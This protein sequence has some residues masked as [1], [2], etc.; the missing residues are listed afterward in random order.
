[1]RIKMV[2]AGNPNSGKT[3]LFNALTGANQYV[4]NWPGV[5]VEK[6][7]GK[8]KSS[9][10]KGYEDIES[11]LVD[12]PGIYSLSPYTLEEVV[13]RN[14]ILDDK[15]DVIINIIDGSNLERNLYLTT[16]LA[17]L[18]IPMVLA[19]NM[20][21]ILKKN[22]DVLD[23]KML[24]MQLGCP[25]VEISALKGTG[26]EELTVKAIETAKLGIPAAVKHIFSGSVEHALAHIEEETIHDMP[27]E[28]QR[29][30]AIKLF[31]KD[32]KIIEKLDI[33]KEALS[34]I[35]RD[36]SICENEMDDDVESIITN[37]RYIFVAAVTGACLKKKG[38]SNLTMSDK[39]DRIVTNRILGLP[40]F[41]A[42]MFV[43][44]FV[45]VTTIGTRATDWTNDV[46]FG[47]WISNAAT[48]GLESIGASDWVQSL[49]V[50]GIIGGIGAPIGFTPQMALVFLFLSFLEDCGY[51]ARVAFIMDRIFRRF[52]LSGKSFIPFLISSGCAVPGIMATRT[53]ENEK[54]RRMTIMTTTAIPCGAKLPVIAAI[55]GFLMG[56]AWWMAPLMYFVGIG[57]AIM[58]CIILKKMKPF[59]GKPAPFVMELPKYH[60]PSIGTL[61]LHTWERVWAF[62]KKAGTILFA[63]CVV[64]WFLSSF[65]FTNGSFGLVEAEDS[66]MAAIGGFIAPIFIPLGFGTWQ[67]VASSIS[68]FVAKEGI[69]S[70]MGVLSG[71]GEIEDYSASMHDAFA[72][73]FPTSIAAVSFLMFNLF[74]SPCLAAISSAA[75]EYGSKRFF[76]FAIAF[77]NIMA[78]CIALLVYQIG[79]LAVG[80][81]SFG[82]GTIVAFIILAAMLYMLFRPDPSKKLERLARDGNAA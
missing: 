5:T 24:E 47:T 51:M 54:D 3:T 76:W 42:V 16:Q 13:A 41:V 71:L 32:E 50:D 73:F 69:I 36:I 53:I 64:M 43:V 35:E 7:S 31:E 79:G 26:I 82:V 75:K 60:I 6:K 62:L 48:K 77:Q 12:L 18:G 21:D 15:P 46:L 80:A 70:T 14:Y 52:G 20:I 40:I 10:K 29:F 33:S 55:A 74:D 72:S 49:V 56:G 19:V 38:K 4:G 59:C 67:S 25:A 78:Y 23:T 57:V 61:L 1:M 11:E 45:S 30:Y 81:I 39:I 27:E 63:C 28:R 65:G 17:E 66:M 22:G 2:L 68:G 44:Y 8:I 37:E 9:M 34:H 58:S